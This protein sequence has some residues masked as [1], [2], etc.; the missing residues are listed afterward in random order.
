[1][2]RGQVNAIKEL[3]PGLTV[4]MQK[5]TMVNFGERPNRTQ[6]LNLQKKQLGG[7]MCEEI[8]NREGK[9]DHIFVKWVKGRR[10]L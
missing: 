8:E 9:Q 2:K 3:K 10:I 1:M 7:G 5:T 6:R 4:K